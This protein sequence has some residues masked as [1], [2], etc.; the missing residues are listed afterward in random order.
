M[1]VPD[2]RGDLVNCLGTNQKEYL[3]KKTFTNLKTKNRPFSLFFGPEMQNDQINHFHK[4]CHH[5]VGC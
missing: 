1:F 2:K 3:T 5:F 4:K